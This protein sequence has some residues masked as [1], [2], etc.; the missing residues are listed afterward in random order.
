MI[1]RIFGGTVIDPASRVQAKLDLYIQDGKILR[2]GP[3]LPEAHRNIAARGKI[4]PPGFIDIHLHEDP[5]VDGRLEQC[6]FP[7][8]LRQ[9]VTTAVGG[10]CGIN[11]ADPAR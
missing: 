10:N 1:T 5:V 2:V 6:I 3:D 11:V 8:M 4:V 7:M 9:G